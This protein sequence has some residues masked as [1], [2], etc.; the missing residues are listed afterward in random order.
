MII[1]LG[2]AIIICGGNQGDANQPFSVFGLHPTNGV[3]IACSSRYFKNAGTTMHS[4]KGQVR[5]DL[6]ILII[7]I[8]YFFDSI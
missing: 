3:P 8:I 2:H 5:L 7:F 1:A 4:P 6:Y